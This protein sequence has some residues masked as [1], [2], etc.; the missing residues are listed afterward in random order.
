MYTVCLTACNRPDLL[1]IT[2]ETF[3]EFA[4]IQPTEFMIYE[5]S[6]LRCNEKLK[7]RYPEITWMEGPER[8][9][10]IVALDIMFSQVQTEYIFHCEDD[11][12][13]LKTGF[14][15]KSINILE[16]I[17]YIYQVRL[18]QLD[19]E[20]SH[21]IS[22]QNGFGILKGEPLWGGLNFNPSLKRKSDYD[23]IG[24]FGAHTE[25]NRWKPWKSEAD[26]S[27]L[28]SKKGFKA[29]ILNED[30]IEHIGNDRHIT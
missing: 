19:K 17:K 5:D 7:T 30:Y 23:L 2:L 11:W 13:F 9:G 18:R 3:F 16:G 29:A 15:M 6:S 14:I 26:I 27:K 20:N 1:A 12:R 28:Y 25:F 8:Y 24:S 21:P 22:W 4:D 10:Q